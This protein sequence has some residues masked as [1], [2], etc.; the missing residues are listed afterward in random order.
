MRR[1]H[2]DHDPHGKLAALSFWLAPE[3]ARSFGGPLRRR[4]LGSGSAM[5]TEIA[6]FSAAGGR[7]PSVARSHVE[8][9][10]LGGRA[11]TARA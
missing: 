3:E 10:G 5:P 9:D 8:Q 1:D 4:P 7:A 11:A 6:R 2:D